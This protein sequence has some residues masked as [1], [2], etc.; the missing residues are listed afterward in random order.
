M[1]ALLCLPSHGQRWTAAPHLAASTPASLPTSVPSPATC[2]RLDIEKNFRARAARRRVSIP[3]LRHTTQRYSCP[4]GGVLC[5]RLRL[6]ARPVSVSRTAC[7]SL[8][9]HST[10]PCSPPC[11]AFPRASPSAPEKRPKTPNQTKGRKRETYLPK[12][13]ALSSYPSHPNTLSS[14]LAMYAV[15]ARQAERYDAVHDTREAHA[16]WSPS[17]QQVGGSVERRYDSEDED[18]L[19]YEY[20]SADERARVSSQQHTPMPTRDIDIDVPSIRIDTH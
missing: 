2:P 7:H 11:T 9:T 3:A 4:S 15:H 18:E 14:T 1:T 16:C 20:F 8:T 5:P 6:D 13:E 10:L 17:S 12:A 19:E